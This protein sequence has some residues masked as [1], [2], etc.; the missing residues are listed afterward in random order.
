MKTLKKAGSGYHLER[1]ELKPAFALL[2]NS[3]RLSR[4][5]GFSEMKGGGSHALNG[6][7]GESIEP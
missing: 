1:F 2:L 7:T 6:K 3:N 4:P 5:L